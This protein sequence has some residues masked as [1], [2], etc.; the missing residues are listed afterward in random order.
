MATYPL[1]E[2]IAAATRATTPAKIS[3]PGIETLQPASQLPAIHTP[4][5]TPHHIQARRGSTEPTTPSTRLRRTSA[6]VGAGQEGCSSICLSS[7]PALAVLT[8][9]ARDTP[10][11]VPGPRLTAARSPVAAIMAPDPFRGTSTVIIAHTPP[12]VFVHIHK[13]GGTSVAT[14]LGRDVAPE[15]LVIPQGSGHR[16]DTHDHALGKHST[17][18]EIRDHIGSEAWEG[19]F[20]FSIVRHPIDRALSLYRYIE[21]QA[22]PTRPPWS[23]RFWHHVSGRGRGRG[24]GP[25]RP[26]LSWPEVRAY[27]DS[28][29]M[30]DFFRHPLL[31]DAPGMKSQSSSLCN[32]SG[33]VIVDFV[34]RYESLDADI[35][36]V[37]RHLGLPDRPLPWLNPSERG[38]LLPTDLSP[39]DRS[40]LVARFEEDF[41]RFDYPL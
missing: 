30:S 19:S 7:A 1:A 17:A 3:R 10:D 41:R 15:A 5:N 9:Q 12:F 31:A 16:V 37:R 21:A 11:P 29:S 22:R 6:G 13:T 26:A 35:G 24:P 27:L 39:E 25:E 34:G 32:S 8:P 33:A 4:A 36:Y 23:R 38:G 2:A 14:S 40:Y 28:D 18:V 20:T